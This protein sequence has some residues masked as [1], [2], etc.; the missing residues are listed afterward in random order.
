ML[1]EGNIILERFETF[2]CHRHFFCLVSN[3]GRWRDWVEKSNRVQSA[4]HTPSF[5]WAAFSNTNL[6]HEKGEI[7]CMA[8]SRFSSSVKHTTSTPLASRARHHPHLELLLVCPSNSPLKLQPMTSRSLSDERVSHMLP[9]ASPASSDVNPIC[10]VPVAAVP[11]YK[12]A[13][14]S[15]NTIAMVVSIDFIG[16]PFYFGFSRLVKVDL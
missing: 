6:T 15:A 2:S 14:T 16:L 9:E 11:A 7:A 1:S 13:G 12:V 10:S 8:S 5:L 3:K 4:I